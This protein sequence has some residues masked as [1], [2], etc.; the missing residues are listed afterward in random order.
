[1]SHF[2]KKC[3]GF[4][5]YTN[6]KNLNCPELWM[7]FAFLKRNS[8]QKVV[9]KKVFMNVHFCSLGMKAY[10]FQV[11]KSQVTVQEQLLSLKSL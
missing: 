11:V 1:M 4:H 3:S 5:S 6:I 7:P 8:F 2:V 10:R 9:T